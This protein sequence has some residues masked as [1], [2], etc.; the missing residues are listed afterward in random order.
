[1]RPTPQAAAMDP[2]PAEQA[3]AV[4]QVIFDQD[5][6]HQVW[7]AIGFEWTMDDDRTKPKLRLLCRATRQMVDSRVLEMST[8]LTSNHGTP[9]QLVQTMARL[10]AECPQL[11]SLKVYGASHIDLPSAL[12]A[13]LPPSLTKL[14]VLA[15]MVS[16]R[17][18]CPHACARPV[19]LAPM[20]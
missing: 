17:D 20:N 19:R 11:N 14:S 15:D 1:M 5:L 4:H 12:L 3:D 2:P 18:T 7:L 13:N 8:F 10:N 6:F 16:S 9:E